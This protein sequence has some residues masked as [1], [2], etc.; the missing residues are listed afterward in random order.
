[1]QRSRRTAFYLTG[2]NQAMMHHYSLDNFP[3]PS[4]NNGTFDM[5][6]Y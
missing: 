6:K 5:G 3:F 2:S 1:M 4:S